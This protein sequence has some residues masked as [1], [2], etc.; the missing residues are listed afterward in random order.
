MPATAFPNGTAFS[1]G[2]AFADGIVVSLDSPLLDVKIRIPAL[3]PGVLRRDR[4][5]ELIERATARPVTTITGP[6]GSGKTVACALWAATQARSRRVAWLSLDSGDRDPARFWAHMSAALAAGGTEAVSGLVP[7]SR[8]SEEDLPTDLMTTMRKLSGSVV[9]VIDDVHMLADSEVLPGL[10]LLV[11]HAPATLRLILSGRCVPGL[12]VARM[13]VAGM[14]SEIRAADLACTAEE[15]EDYFS[16]LGLATSEAERDLLLGCTEGWMA[17]ARLAALIAG[18]DGELSV[19]A[20]GTDPIVADYLRDEILDQQPD[21]IRQFLRQTSVAEHLTGDFADWLTGDTGG[22]RILDQ[23]SRENNFVYRDAAGSYRCHRLMRQVL[24]S[25]LNGELSEEVPRLLGRAARWYARG[26]D[27]IEAVR[28]WAGTAEWNYASMALTEAGLAGVLPDRAAELEAVLG[29]FPT[30]RRATDPAVAAALGVA[31]LCRGDPASADA[32]LGLAT[33]GLVDR[34]PYRLVIELWLAVLRV[35][36]QPE[37]L[38]SCWA[39][40][41]QAQF[42]ASNQAEHQAAGMLWLTLGTVMLRRWE[43][44][45]ARRALIFARNQLTAAGATRLR[46]RALGWLALTEVLYGD[47]R[48]ATAVIERLRNTIPPDPAAGCFATIA[49]GHL[50][51]DR[52]DLLTAAQLLDEANPADITRLPGEPDADSMLM[53]ARVRVAIGEGDAAGAR[54]MLRLAREKYGADDPV[55]RAVD[56]EIAL[57]TGDPGLAAVALD[58]SGTPADGS[59]DGRGTLG[60]AHQL[61]AHARLLLALGEPAAALEAARHCAS[62]SEVTLRDRISALVAASLASR[63]LGADDEA[64]MFLEE[65]LTLAEPHQSYRPFLD[66]GGDVHSAIAIL[67][68]PD[69]PAAGF[70]ARVREH[71]ICRPLPK[72]AAAGSRDRDAPTLTASELAVLRLLRSHMTNQEIAD[73]LYLSVNTVKTHLRSVYHKFGVTSRRDAVDRGRRLNMV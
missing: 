66:M 55:Q 62:D 34:T 59:A 64:A 72:T 5:T 70:A 63:R 68:P 43:V 37:A 4:L 7:R 39:L 18:R 31:R 41:E 26:G 2:T 67:V 16:T 13:R 10:A 48:A 24:L 9:L 51:I 54:D 17:G 30:A 47:L 14:L 35:A 32:Y 21:A 6:A 49:A 57:V 11:H 40:A 36:R 52:D 12:H 38:P 22:A 15:A 45:A 8:E 29:L 50:A 23:L 33:A 61:A 53:L 19:S 3:G 27:V 44:V 46:E 58:L 71:L 60:R 1:S 42:K 65:A 69:S 56:A 25:E 73:A 20:I 28:C